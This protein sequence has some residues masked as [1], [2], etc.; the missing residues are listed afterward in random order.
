MLASPDEFPDWTISSQPALTLAAICLRTP[1]TFNPVYSASFSAL[2]HPSRV[3]LFTW[4]RI[5]LT[6]ARG[7]LGSPFRLYAWSHR[8]MGGTSLAT[9][10]SPQLGQL[11]LDGRQ[12]GSGL[13]ALNAIPST[14]G[15]QCANPV[16]PARF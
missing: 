5:A 15:S 10:L 1:R 13:V 3:W 4:V 6:T 2:T 9:A 8:M 14:L 11:S 7:R 16:L 12:L